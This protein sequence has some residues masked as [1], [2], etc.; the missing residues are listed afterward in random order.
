[1]LKKVFLTMALM[2]ATLGVFS[3]GAVLGQKADQESSS[4]KLQNGQLYFDSKLIRSGFSVYQNNFVFLYFYVPSRGLYTVSD[5]EFSG[6][7]QAG[8]FEGKTL[9]F[10][11]DQNQVLLESSSRML[12]ADNRAWVK[13]DPDFKLPTKTVVLGYGS[14]IDAP[15]KWPEQWAQRKNNG[16]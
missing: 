6:A 4:I 13:H 16:K 2:T 11:I 14:S 8:K 15:Y 3:T 1:M 7:L 9:S 10:E 5:K 12:Q